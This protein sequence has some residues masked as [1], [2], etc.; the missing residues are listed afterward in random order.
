MHKN[1]AVSL[2]HQIM[3]VNL[4]IS[5]SCGVR[6]VVFDISGT[7]LDFGCLGPVAAFLELFRRHGVSISVEEAR[8]PMGTHKRDHIWTL[9]TDPTISSRWESANGS[10]PTREL[11]NQLCEEFAPLQTE[12]VT[13]HTDLIPG[14]LPVL[15]QLRERE[16][17][18]INTTGFESCMIRNLIP[19]VAE[20]GYTPDLWVCPDHV[21]GGRPAP[22]MIFHAAKQLDIYP[23]HT[24]VKVGDTPADIAE[25]HAAGAWVVSVVNSGNEVGCSEAELS[26]LPPAEREAKIFAA[27]TKLSACGP[28]YLIDTVA[29]LMPV[30]DAI[31]ER[32]ARGEKPTPAEFAVPIFANNGLCE[33]SA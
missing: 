19:A 6:A 15:A 25:G 32:I 29:D 7:V 12:M 2:E 18:V 10:V 30:I 3:G 5:T 20:A 28:H 26:A 4:P 13:H 22:W 11:L 31:S 21:G 33:Q 24:F 27:Q 16:I 14:V 23:T 17:K 9:L 1:G 8:R